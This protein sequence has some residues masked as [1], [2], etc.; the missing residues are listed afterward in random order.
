LF[1]TLDHSRIDVT[2]ARSASGSRWTMPHMQQREAGGR[3]M[4]S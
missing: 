1:G 4:T 2:R 3:E